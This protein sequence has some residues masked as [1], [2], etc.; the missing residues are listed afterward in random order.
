MTPSHPKHENRASLKI[1]QVRSQIGNQERIVR[2]LTDGLGLGRIGKSVI[3]PDTPYTRGMVAKLAHIVK[4]EPV[5]AG[6]VKLA[7]AAARPAAEHVAAVAALPPVA[8]KPAKPAAARPAKKKTEAA[9]EVKPA[10]KGKAE[11]AR[12]GKAEPAAKH[13]AA[14]EKKGKESKKDAKAPAKPAARK[15][16]K[17]AKE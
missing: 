1:T 15:P 8:P 6:E 14:P 17:K 7:P 11:P 13:K 3:L 5:A 16:A 9:H 10:A 4:M 12:K 2:V